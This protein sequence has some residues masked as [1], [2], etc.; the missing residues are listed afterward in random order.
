MS[1]A[2]LSQRIDSWLW[3]ARFFKTRTLAGTVVSTGKVRLTRNGETSRVQKTS[4]LIKPGDELTFPQS[5][6][7]RIVRVASCSTRRG[8][9][10]EAQ[11]LYEDLTPA[12][13]PKGERK[14]SPAQRE[15]GAGRPTKKERRAVDQLQDRFGDPDTK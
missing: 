15:E 10:P 5:K 9:A 12:P 2:P 14:T 3:H 8:P 6:Q 1:N 7:L 4:N 11:A 13:L